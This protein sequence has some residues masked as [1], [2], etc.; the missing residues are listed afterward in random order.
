MSSS[1]LGYNRFRGFHFRRLKARLHN[2]KTISD[3]PGAGREGRNNTDRGEAAVGKET[4]S[5]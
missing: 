4:D 3:V 2:G 1:G 5:V